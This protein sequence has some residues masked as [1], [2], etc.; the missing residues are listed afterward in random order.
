MTKKTVQ[1]LSILHSWQLPLKTRLTRWLIPTH[2]KSGSAFFEGI[3]YCLNGCLIHVDTRNYIEY[4]IFAEGGY[5]DYLSTLIK[6]YLKPN[7]V[8]F[9]VGANI[10]IHSLSAATKQNC[11]I[12]S[13][14]PV[15]FIREKLNR[16]IKLNNY[17]NINVVPLA[18]SNENKEIKTSYSVSSSNQ[19]TFSI[20]DEE[21][22]TSIIKCVK[23]D[24]Y[25]TENN[26]DN[27]SV[28]K[29]DVEGF[30]FSV[31]EG[32]EDTIKKQKP[33]IFFE[34]DTCYIYRDNKTIADYETLF[35]ETLGYQ[36]FIIERFILIPCKSLVSING[37][38]ELMAIPKK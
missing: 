31:I 38:K 9:D 10:G 12:Y 16:N 13:F 34:F 14:E 32:L 7:T 24:D 4:K 30:E 37:M 20:I 15:D 6:H 8:L 18:L 1:K 3:V 22:G 2:D 5:E 19:G 26:I 33:I 27:I 11:Q 36:L 29:I 25:V 21:K 28:I 17:D 23:G 35:F